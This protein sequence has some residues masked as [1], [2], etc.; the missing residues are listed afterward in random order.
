MII[1]LKKSTEEALNLS[2]LTTTKFVPFGDATMGSCSYKCTKQHCL[3]GLQYAMTLGWYNYEK[4]DVQEYQHFEK[5]ENG[6]LIWILPGKFI[7]FSSP[8]NQPASQ[9]D[10]LV[11]MRQLT[12]M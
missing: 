8:L 5:V 3:K 11:T 12:S 4:F 9:K 7:A 10:F 2:F 1:A 6:D